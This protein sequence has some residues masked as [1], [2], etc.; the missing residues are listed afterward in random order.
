L[1]LVPVW[2]DWPFFPLVGVDELEAEL[3][4]ADPLEE[5]AKLPD[6]APDCPFDAAPLGEFWDGPEGGPNV[7]AALEAASMVG[8]AGPGVAALELPLAASDCRNELPS[9]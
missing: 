1:A 4:V 7:C 5:F 8:A 6:A 3:S 9:D 2:V